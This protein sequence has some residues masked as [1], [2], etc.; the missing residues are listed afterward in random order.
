MSPVPGRPSAAVGVGPP[1]V[2]R[3]GVPGGRRRVRVATLAAAAGFVGSLAV[4]NWLSS[5]FGRVPVGCGLHAAAGTYTAG[6]ALALRDLVQDGWGRVGAVAAI[7]VG[8]VASWLVAAPSM[9]LAS[10]AAVCFSEMADLA[11]YTPLRGRARAGPARWVVAVVAS[12]AVGAVVDSLL[13]VAMAFGLGGVAGSLAGQL[14]GKGWATGAFVAA[15]VAAGGW[16]D[17]SGEPVQRGG[18]GGDAGR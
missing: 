16:R 14:A 11:V 12:N 8:A 9:A 1:E 3:H 5:R 4:A 10:A 2:G 15:G 13:F 18:A 7:A 6:L 17:L